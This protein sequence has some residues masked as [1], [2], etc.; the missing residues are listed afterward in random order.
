[1]SAHLADSVN[2]HRRLCQD[3]ADV[4][5]MDG[6]EGVSAAMISDALATVGAAIYPCET[7]AMK[8]FFLAF[9]LPDN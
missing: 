5:E 8:M 7:V 4:L 3:V 1:M 6:I 9:I 2:L